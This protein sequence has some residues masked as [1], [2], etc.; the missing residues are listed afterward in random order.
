MA[1]IT[2]FP[3]NFSIT[4]DGAGVAFFTGKTVI[5]NN[6]VVVSTRVFMY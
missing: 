6:G 2:I 5:K 4:D 1:L 3:R